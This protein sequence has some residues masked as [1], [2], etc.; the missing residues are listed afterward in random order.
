MKSANSSLDGTVSNVAA[1]FKRFGA[2][3]QFN[4]YARQTMM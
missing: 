2:A 4:R 1:F 3:R